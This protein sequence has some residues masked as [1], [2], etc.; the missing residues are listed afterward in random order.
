MP[1]LPAIG[2]RVSLRYRLPAGSVPPLS[3]VVGHLLATEPLVRVQTKAGDVVEL[4]AADI[5]VA[6]A[7]PAAPVRLSQIRRLEHAA[8]LAW[9]GLEQQWL[10]G[11]LLRA[12][13][14][15]THRANSAVPLEPQADL[16]AAPDIAAW[17]RE[18]GLRGGLAIPHRLVRLPAGV[19]LELPNRVMTR[20]LAD[21]P[22]AP[23][24]TLLA[25][26]DDEWLRLYRREV[27]VEV[28]TAVIDG[29]VT[30][31][32]R[33]GAAVARAAVTVAPDGTRWAGLSAVHVAESARRSGHARTLCQGLLGWAAER[34]AT[35]AYVQVLTDNTAATALYESMGFTEHHR[36]GYLDLRRV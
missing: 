14:G 8:A 22:P 17:Y 27:P 35:H 1:E 23:P 9:P 15:H 10:A 19:R 6:R 2:T 24:V 4:A 28:L 7:L 21:L 18:R 26:P 3:D 32:I 36:C 29:E 33:P 12:A 16:R 30:F 20:R 25:R 34:G 5:L 31:G 11:W 13:G